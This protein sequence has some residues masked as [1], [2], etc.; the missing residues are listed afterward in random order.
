MRVCRLIRKHPLSCPCLTSRTKEMQ[1]T[2]PKL[3]ILFFLQAPCSCTPSHSVVIWIYMTCPR[4]D[5]RL[6]EMTVPRPGDTPLTYHRCDTCGGVWIR[7]FDAN[8]LP[9]SEYAKK[10]A[11]QGDALRSYP[12]DGTLPGYLVCPVCAFAIPRA[13][14][15]N[16]P[17]D[18]RIF[19]CPNGHGY[20]FPSGQLARFKEAQETKI[21]Y[22]KLWHLPLSS[23]GATLLTGFFGLL[24]S[25][26][27]IMSA[28][29]NYQAVDQT[30]RAQDLIRYQQVTAIPGTRNVTVTATTA[31]KVTLS[32]WV[33][34]IRGPDLSSPDGLSHTAELTDLAAGTHTYSFTFIRG[35][36]MLRSRTQSFTVR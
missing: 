4:N 6:R 32:L 19:R 12:D 22:H 2:K 27:L 21:A 14:G 26:G 9:V 1:N 13:T 18:V 36:K 8:F 10:L 25:L 7:G 16:I 11:S 20:F 31:T 35:G 3:R 15:P 34:G 17:D 30:T 24:L 23:V 33:D 28:L 5:G 29:R